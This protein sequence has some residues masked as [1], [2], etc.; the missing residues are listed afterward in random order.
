MIGANR[1]GDLTQR[2]GLAGV[3][4]EAAKATFAAAEAD[5]LHVENDRRR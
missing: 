2:H 5:T 3:H 1:E 4:A